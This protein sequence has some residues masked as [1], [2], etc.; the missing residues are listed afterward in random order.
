MFEAAA[1]DVD[2][3]V[4]EDGPD[5]DVDH[6]DFEDEEVEEDGV[7]KNKLFNFGV[8][9]WVDFDLISKI[10]PGDKLKTQSTRG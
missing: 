2:E 4:G 7:E 8:G 5:L 9:E 6:L 3:V 1:R 10:V